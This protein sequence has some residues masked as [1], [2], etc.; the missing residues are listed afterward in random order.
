MLKA[1]TFPSQQILIHP[2]NISLLQ[3]ARTP[4]LIR[5]SLRHRA[6]RFL[7]WFEE[8]EQENGRPVSKVS[9]VEDMWD[10]V[11]QAALFTG[12]LVS[13]YSV[14]LCIDSVRCQLVRHFC[15]STTPVTPYCTSLQ[16]WRKR[17]LESPS[18]TSIVSRTLS[19]SPFS[20]QSN[21][22]QN[23]ELVKNEWL[24]WIQGEIIVHSTHFLEICSWLHATG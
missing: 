10:P 1:L 3:R 13:L 6:S 19:L 9:V 5:G 11:K 14:E 23:S 17:Y 12:W 15:R 24:K 22:Q 21:N 7:S 18:F 4:A 8:C 20:K 16:S 2:P